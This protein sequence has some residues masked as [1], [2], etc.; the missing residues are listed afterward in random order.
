MPIDISGIKSDIK[1]K[2]SS[3]NSR[4]WLNSDI[5]GD[6][7]IGGGPNNPIREQKKLAILLANIFA[8]WTLMN[9]DHYIKA[10]EMDG[11]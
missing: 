3:E 4:K 8:L 6:V 5:F 10:E 1:N 9:S 11:A 7:K 2:L